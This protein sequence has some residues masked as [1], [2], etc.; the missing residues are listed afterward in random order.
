[1]MQGQ[2]AAKRKRKVQRIDGPKEPKP[3]R[4]GA[5]KSYLERLIDSTWETY[6]SLHT[7]PIKMYGRAADVLM[8]LR[9]CQ[10]AAIGE[11]GDKGDY[12]MRTVD[13]NLAW[14]SYFTMFVK[15]WITIPDAEDVD[16][17]QQWWHS[18]EASK[19]SERL[20][21]IA[22]RY[23][24]CAFRMGETAPTNEELLPLGMSIL[25]VHKLEEAEEKRR[26]WL[27]TNMDKEEQSRQFLKEK[28]AQTPW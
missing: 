28:Y 15:E 27:A 4:K 22:W 2:P 9:F 6:S 25:S 23:A 17:S 14:P 26:E 8:D 18:A 7:M 16:K 13:H 21:R 5:K 24:L 19:K 3:K 11:W 10:V 12:K 20:V 1:M